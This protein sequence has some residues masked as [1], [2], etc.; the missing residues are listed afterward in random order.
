M[1]YCLA[2]V[3]ILAL[4]LAGCA[5]APRPTRASPGSRTELAGKPAVKAFHGRSESNTVTRAA[6]TTSQATTTN[7][8]GTSH[9]AASFPGA[10]YHKS[11]FSGG[12]GTGAH[13]PL[14]WLYTGL[15]VCFLVWLVLAVWFA[16]RRRH[17]AQ[18]QR[19]ARRRRRRRRPRHALSPSHRPAWESPRS[20]RRHVATRASHSRGHSSHR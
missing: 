4:L 20:R 18:S 9:S 5:T 7:T 15:G 2:L 3:T 8:S 10:R 14:F 6:E 11:I 19:S 17:K 16:V 1:R 12:I 13:D